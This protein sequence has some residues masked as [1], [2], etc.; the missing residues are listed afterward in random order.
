MEYKIVT[1]KPSRLGELPQDA[2]VAWISHVSLICS[3]HFLV[4]I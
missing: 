1:K 3:V 4:Q 2:F